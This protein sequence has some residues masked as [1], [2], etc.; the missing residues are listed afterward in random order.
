MTPVTKT[1]S[2]AGYDICYI[3]EGS[4]EPMVFLHNGGGLWQIWVHQIAYFS[5]THR[6]IAVQ[7]PGYEPGTHVRQPVTLEVYARILRELVLKLGLSQMVLVGNC[8]GASV[9]IHYQNEYPEEVKRLILMNICPG[10]RAVKPA[11]LRWLL[12]DV[13]HAGLRKA[14]TH[15][16]R[17][18]FS[19]KYVRTIFPAALFGSKMP[20]Q[21]FLYALYKQ[22]LSIPGITDARLNL[23]FSSDSYTLKNIL[24]PGTQLPKSLLIWGENNHVAS[25]EKEGYYHQQLCQIPDIH[26][27]AGAGH[28]AMYESPA[29][30]NTLIENYIA[31]SG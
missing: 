20:E 3:D 18:I 30:V 7:W 13:Q 6:V 16:L 29:E 11:G 15:I 24:K 4:G 17:L 9:A 1:L 28:L 14:L 22:K 10:R 27:I 5:K 23:L 12:F 2:L 31:Y 25:L 26:V 8:I 21:D 19:L